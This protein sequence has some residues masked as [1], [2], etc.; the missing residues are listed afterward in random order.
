MQPTGP[1][2]SAA[3]RPARL[4]CSSVVREKFMFFIWQDGPTTR[5]ALRLVLSIDRCRTA[6]QRCAWTGFCIFLIRSLA[7]SSKIGSE[8]FF[9][10]AGSGLDV[11][12]TVKTLL[13]VFLTCIYP[14]SN[15]SRFACVKLVP[16]PNRYRIKTYGYVL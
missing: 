11:V 6:N 3:G 12:F 13:V 8:V 5:P 16:D 14:D 7:A 15:R 10:A 1:S 2:C 4:L 9:P